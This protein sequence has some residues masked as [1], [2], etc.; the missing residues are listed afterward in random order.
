MDKTIMKQEAYMKIMKNKQKIEQ[1]IEKVLQLI[2]RCKEKIN[3]EN[4]IPS[5]QKY[6]QQIDKYNDELTTLQSTLKE[7]NGIKIKF[8]KDFNNI[9]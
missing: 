5:I 4:F 6:Y 3:N 8:F 2:Q 1:R 7:I 9:D